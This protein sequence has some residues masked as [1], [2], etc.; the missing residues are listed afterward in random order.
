M[1]EQPTA[2][3]IL[4]A[5]QTFAGNVDK[6]FEALEHRVGH[7]ESNMTSM[8]SS[9]VTKDYLDD[10][11]AEHGSR[12]GMLIRQTNKKIDALTDALVSIGSLPVQ[13]A[14]RIS[15]ME[16]FGSKS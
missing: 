6:R 14:K 15:G 10:K 16:P 7:L 8:K 12:Y 2:L 3:E 11:L 9:M 4:E 5:I 1:K 13:V